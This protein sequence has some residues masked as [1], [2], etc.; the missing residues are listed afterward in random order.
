MGCRRGWPSPRPGGPNDEILQVGVAS[1]ANSG[2][3]LAPS[4]RVEL[5]GFEVAV[6]EKESRD[7]RGVDVPVLP[8]RAVVRDL[9]NGLPPAPS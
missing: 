7:G 5:V 8:G 1:G 6:V 3:G 2:N 4:T 9:L